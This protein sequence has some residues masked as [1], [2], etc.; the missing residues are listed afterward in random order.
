MSDRNEV[1]S[2]DCTPF[3]EVPTTVWIHS[4]WPMISGDYTL[5]SRVPIISQSEHCSWPMIS[6]DCTLFSGIPILP[7]SEYTAAG[8]WSVVIV[9]RSLGFLPQPS[10]STVVAN[11]QS[12]LYPVLW[13][14]YPTTVWIHCS[15]AMISGDRTPLPGVPITSQSEHC[16]WPTIS[17]DCTLF[18]GVPT[19]SQSKHQ[20]WPTSQS[21]WCFT[22]I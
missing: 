19:T 17:G 8:Q 10:L 11:D 7:Q 16:S 15:W 18:S 5:F 21:D 14:S 22:S 3:S 6:G 1:E 13:G 20:S 4:S 9:P 2:H 12:W